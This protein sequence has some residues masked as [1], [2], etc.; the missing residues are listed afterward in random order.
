MCASWR[1]WPSGH[2]RENGRL[3][4]DFLGPARLPSPPAL[5][6]EP[7]ESPVMSEAEMRR[8]EQENLLN[9]LRLAGGKVYGAGGA[10]ELLGVPP[11]TLASRLRKL[12]TRAAR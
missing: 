7:P 4:F 5:A 2:H 3:T 11:T 1:T 9:A 8:R 10:A 6:L 12:G